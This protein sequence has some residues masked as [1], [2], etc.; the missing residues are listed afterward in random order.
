VADNALRPFVSQG[1]G[2]A[3]LPEGVILKSSPHRKYEE[4]VI[5]VHHFGGTKF[6]SKRHQDYLNEL[7]FDCV[8]FDLLYHDANRFPKSKQTLVDIARG[9]R[10]AW[11]DQIEEVL[12]AISEPK[13]VF[14]FSMPGGAALEAMSRTGA[15]DM[16]AWICEGGPFLSVA[17]CY[18]NYMNRF[19]PDMW[20][21]FKLS[22]VAATFFAMGI[23]DYKKDVKSYFNG[24]PNGFPILSI[25][26]WQ[27]ALVPISAIDEFFEQQSHAGLEILSLPEADH[28]QGLK[29]YPKDYKPR[30]SKF[31]RAKATKIAREQENT[32]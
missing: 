25:R 16:S 21:P 29:E 17:Q 14:S 1:E 11:A 4:I 24:L 10:H 18:W 23:Y 31:L 5:F 32:R 28:L 13:I 6:T 2:V 9:F 3:S 19:H 26:A 20:V 12:Q 30:L 22:A 8:S 15:R 27:D 7:G